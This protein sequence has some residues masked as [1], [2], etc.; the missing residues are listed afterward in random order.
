MKTKNKFYRSQYMIALVEE[1][2]F[3]F[4]VYLYDNANDMA[5]S[6]NRPIDS[7]NSSLHR[8]ING[9]MSGIFINGIRYKVEFIRL[10]KKEIKK[11]GKETK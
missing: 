4:I 9:D 1:S 8:L 5:I 2:E 6:L 11:Y 3:E 10:N 7:V